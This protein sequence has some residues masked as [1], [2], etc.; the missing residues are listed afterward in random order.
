MRIRVDE[1][2]L[3]WLPLT[4]RGVAA[5]ARVSLRR[6]L[7]AQLLFAAAAG[8]AFALLIE[9]TWFATIRE[10]IATLPANGQIQHGQ[11]EWP[12]PVPADLAGGRF[13]KFSIDPAHSG[14]L[15]Q[16]SDVAIEL[17]QTNIWIISLLGYLEAPYPPG[18]SVALNR[19]ELEPW[20]GAREPF[21][22][23]GAGGAMGLLLL[24]IWWTLG[25][26]YAVIAWVLALL[27]NRSLGLAG[28]WKLAGTAQLPGALLLA[29]SFLSYRFGWLSLLHLVL[30]VGLSFAVAWFYVLCTPFL[31]PPAENTGAA[32]ANPFLTPSG[33]T[34]EKTQPKKNPFTRR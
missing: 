30:S 27:A 24:V 14:E 23:L 16:E 34:A 18:W 13:L 15:G 22:V 26:V 10:T 28:A 6:V 25:L 8:I 12:E 29:A 33:P 17:G 1:P 32:K 20:W 21:L 31:L 4:L 2:L 11:L 5:F 3:N 19:A 7:L 9:T